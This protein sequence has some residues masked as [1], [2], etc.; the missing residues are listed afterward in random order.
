VE[1]EKIDGHLDHLHQMKNQKRGCPTVMGHPFHATVYKY[2]TIS[3]NLFL[4]VQTTF[5]I[6]LFFGCYGARQIILPKA[7]FI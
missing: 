1:E 6:S 7:M 2:L 3:R 5:S 4:C